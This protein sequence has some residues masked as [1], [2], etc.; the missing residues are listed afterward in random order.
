MLKRTIVLSTQAYLKKE[1]DQLVIQQ[2]EESNSVPI[3]DIGVLLLESYQVT[4][5]QP[6]LSALMANDAVVITCDASHHP[7]GIMLPVSGNSIHTAILR[8]QLEASVPFRKQLWQQ[9]AKAKILNQADLLDRIGEVSGPLRRW[10]K[11]VRSGDSSNME[12]RAAKY[13][14]EHFLPPE[15]GFQR[16]PEGSP[17]NNL[18]NYGYAILRAAVARALVSS[19]LHPAIGI[20]HRNEYNAFVLADDIMEPYRPFVDWL[21]RSLVVE[22]EPLDDLTPSLKKKILSI[23]TVD[24]EIDGQTRPLYLALSTTTKSLA[25]CYAKERRVL[26]HPRLPVQPVSSDVESRIL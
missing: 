26:K 6:V 22:G 24:V 5:T 1:W 4:V 16:G 17:P 20:H 12:A 14:W 19:G 8:D 10:A 13:Y 21:V 3:E 25:D 2:G 11:G 18:L 7:S 15:M 9:T 23:L